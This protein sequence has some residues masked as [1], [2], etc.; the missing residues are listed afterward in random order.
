MDEREGEKEGSRR[1]GGRELLTIGA[2]DCE[3]KA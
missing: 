2:T 3:I 1:G